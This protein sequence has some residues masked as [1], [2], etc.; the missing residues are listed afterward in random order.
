MK[1]VISNVPLHQSIR[2]ISLPEYQNTKNIEPLFTSF[3]IPLYPL[4]GTTHL[5]YFY[6]MFSLVTA[7]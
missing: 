4:N 2:D 6:A 1:N 7:V 3:N 5:L